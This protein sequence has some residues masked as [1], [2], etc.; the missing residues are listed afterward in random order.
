M[1]IMTLLVEIYKFPKYT[2]NKVFKT[3]VVQLQKCFLVVPIAVAMSRRALDHQRDFSGW[4]FEWHQQQEWQAGWCRTRRTL[5]KGCLQGG[6]GPSPQKPAVQT[7]PD[8]SAPDS[9]TPSPCS[10]TEA[11]R[12]KTEGSIRVWDISSDVGKCSRYVGQF[13]F[14][15]LMSC[16]W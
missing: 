8:G 15:T 1:E 6:S 5:S 9:S 11:D 13:S 4:R 14:L 10:P 3:E 2:C 7:G 16:S 12:N